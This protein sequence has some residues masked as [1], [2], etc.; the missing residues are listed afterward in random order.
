MISG[1]EYA[2]RHQLTPKE[3]EVFLAFF[4]K[5]YTVSQLSEELGIKNIALHRTVQRLR[6]KGVISLKDRDEKGSNIL[7]LNMTTM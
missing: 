6:F 4:K 3:I 5:P 1:L 7:E 2:Y